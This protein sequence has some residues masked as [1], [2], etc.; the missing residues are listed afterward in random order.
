MAFSD[1]CLPSLPEETPGRGDEVSYWP[2]VRELYS[3][4]TSSGQVKVKV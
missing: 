3:S 1:D 2:T 4:R